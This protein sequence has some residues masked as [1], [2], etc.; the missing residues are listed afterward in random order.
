MGFSGG[1]AVSIF[2]TASLWISGMWR[3]HDAI[4]TLIQDSIDM[5]KSGRVLEQVLSRSKVN[6]KYIH[7]HLSNKTAVKLANCAAVTEL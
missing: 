2:M 6:A 5:S 7:A 4:R 3:E 1:V